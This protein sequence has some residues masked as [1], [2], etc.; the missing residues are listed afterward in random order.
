MPVVGTPSLDQLHVFVTVVDEGSFA[1]AG[2]RLNRATSAISYSVSTLE[3]QLGIELFDRGNPR[4][5]R[6]THAGQTVLARA[7]SVA[8]GVGELKARVAGILEGLEAELTL[9]VDVMLPPQRLADAVRKFEQRFPTVTLRLNVEALSAVSQLVHRGAARL[10]IGGLLHTT[11][12]NLELISIGQVEM[13]P[14]AVPSHPLAMEE[15]GVIGA[16]KRYRQLILTVRAAFDQGPSVAVLAPDTWSLADLGAKRALLL[17]GVGWGYMPMHT[18]DDDIDAKRLVRLDIPE[19]PGG[20][21]PLQTMYRTDTPPGPAGQW[22]IKQFVEQ[23]SHTE[24]IEV[25]NAMRPP[26]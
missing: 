6:L 19:L 14:V 9:V 25:Q 18:V 13:I 2:R 23:A 20:A 7:R 15:S 11:E 12:P 5:P 10:G 17:A 8:L 3:N 24:K 22:L 16:S 4:R 1:A 21:Y 26:H